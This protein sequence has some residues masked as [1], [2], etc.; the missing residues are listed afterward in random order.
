MFPHCT[1]TG[2]TVLFSLLLRFY[3]NLNFNQ[4]PMHGH[5]VWLFFSLPSIIMLKLLFLLLL[6]HFVPSPSPCRWFLISIRFAGTGQQTAVVHTLMAIANIYVI[7]WASIIVKIF[8]LKCWL[9]TSRK[10]KKLKKKEM[11]KNTYSCTKNHLKKWKKLKL[12]YSH[13]NH[14]FCEMSYHIEV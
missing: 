13:V 12:Q 7:T 5:L 4:R 2:K 11:Y 10:N 3:L 1:R 14:L 8:L 6:R 9:T